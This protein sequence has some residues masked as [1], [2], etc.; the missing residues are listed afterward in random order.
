MIAPQALRRSLAVVLLAGVVGFPAAAITNLTV[1]Y[2]QTIRAV[3]DQ[4][5]VLGRLQFMISAA[6]NAQGASSDIDLYQD[7][8]MT[9]NGP[10]H[11]TANLQTRVKAVAESVGA[12]VMEVREIKPRILDGI[13][14]LGI[15]STVSGSMEAIHE[16]LVAIETEKPLLFI[17]TAQFTS[18]QYHDRAPSEGTILTMELVIFTALQP[19]L[20]AP[21]KESP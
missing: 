16:A 12:E 18:G 8:F 11:L 20:T 1:A 13:T 5:K 17:E 7:W 9:G 2:T 19:S 15:A 6:G 10:A 4:R 21:A 3:E 14:Y